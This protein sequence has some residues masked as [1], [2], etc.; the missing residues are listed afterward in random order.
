MG[1]TFWVTEEAAVSTRG[2]G[3]GPEAQGHPSLATWGAWGWLWERPHHRPLTTTTKF[4]HT[5][6]YVLTPERGVK[7]CNLRCLW[8]SM[9]ILHS[10]PFDCFSRRFQ[11]LYGQWVWWGYTIADRNMRSALDS[12]SSKQAM[13]KNVHLNVK[14]V[15]SIPVT[16]KWNQ[17]VS[18]MYLLEAKDQ[19]SWD[20]SASSRII[21]GWLFLIPSLVLF[22]GFILML[23]LVLR[24]VL[25]ST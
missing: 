24:E 20:A 14:K 13:K 10:S 1:T 3:R 18:T 15:E 5:K 16:M 4:K 21:R 17:S 9:P 19:Q 22:N 25:Y 6:I 8:G 7:Y 23:S 2:G 11:C 12:S